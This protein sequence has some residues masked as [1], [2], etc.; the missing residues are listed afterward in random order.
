MYT[1]IVIILFLFSP[2]SLSIIIVY[3]FLLFF[4]NVIMTP[5]EWKFFQLHIIFKLIIFSLLIVLNILSIVFN[6]PIIGV[7]FLCL[8]FFTTII[9][10]SE[11][12][13]V[14]YTCI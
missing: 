2:S 4:I 1:L 9:L 3:V 11:E 8:L 5:V 14:G 13:R 6:S 12:R 7:S 10:R